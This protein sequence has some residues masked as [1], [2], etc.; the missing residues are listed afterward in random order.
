[1]NQ[2]NEWMIKVWGGA[3][4]FDASPSI[5]KDYGI[6][7]GYYYFV[8]E[9][10]KD[11]FLEI[12]DNPIYS[13][14]GIARNVNY[15]VMSHKRTIFVGRYQYKNRF[16]VV[17][18]DFGFEYPDESAIA[19]FTVGD[20]SC[21]CNIS[22]IIRWEHG[23]NSVPDLNCSMEGKN[24]IKLTAYKVEHWESDYQYFSGDFLMQD[25]FRKNTL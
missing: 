2:N 20:N 16:F 24:K 11:A 23:V 14:Q 10:A 12:I 25:I 17:H 8:D 1:M 6:K 9:K 7:E 22:S 21:D 3:W 4:N 13:N 18:Y 5:E 15:G 19:D